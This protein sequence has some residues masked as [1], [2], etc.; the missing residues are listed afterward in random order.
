MIGLWS[1]FVKLSSVG[2]QEGVRT[3]GTSPDL[4]W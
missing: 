1:F 2:S 3:F 4:L